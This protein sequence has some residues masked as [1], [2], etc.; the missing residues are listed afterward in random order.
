MSWFSKISDTYAGLWKLIIRPP[1]D[2]YDIDE[3]GPQRFRIGQ[4]QYER[5]DFQLTNGRGMRL[6]CSHYRPRGHSD[7]SERLPCVVYLHG[8]CSSRVEACE[9]VPLLLPKGMTLLSLDLAGSGHSEGE[10]IS[11][12]HWEEQDLSVVI[13]H[14]R[15][16]GRASAIGLWGR[17]MG[18]ATSVLRAAEDPG[19]AGCVMDSPFGSLRQVAEELVCGGSVPIPTFLLGMA[20][21]VVGSEVR[22]RAD[23]ELTELC[24]ARKARFAVA[25]ALFGVASDDN[26]V[27]P[28]HTQDIYDAWGGTDKSIITFTGGHNGQRPDA[29]RDKAVKFLM[30][31]LAQAQTEAFL[32]YTL[33]RA[34]VLRVAAELEDREAAGEDPAKWDGA[35][36]SSL[37]GL[38][39]GHGSG[40]SSDMLSE[41][42]SMGFDADSAAAAMKRTSSVEAA[43]EWI[44]QQ[45]IEAL[46]QFG[47]VELRAPDR[48]GHGL[49][50]AAPAVASS[51]QAGYA[52]Q[53]PAAVAEDV[54]GRRPSNAAV[55]AVTEQL[56]QL[57][58]SSADAAEAA[59]RCSSVEAAMEWLIQTGKL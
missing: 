54:P 26:F 6:E 17:S 11:L 39:L 9:A 8:N 38:P 41:L 19:I 42:V 16:P 58:I 53:K 14:L 15:G 34:S 32:K 35:V 3:L 36:P 43:V 5:V 31:R 44:M 20:L 59:R 22:S 30:E 29:F 23:F 12:G 47:N 4:K 45:S 52:E 56:M 46:D 13:K 7:S 50:G 33:E 37:S 18:A 1:R 55:T 49:D 48:G 57:G 25:P 51:R 24:P 28:H 2:K 27:L 40:K 21:G 10:Y